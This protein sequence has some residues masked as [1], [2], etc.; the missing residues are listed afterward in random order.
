MTDDAEESEAQ[1]GWKEIAA[2]LRQTLAGKSREAGNLS[3]DD[4]QK[5]VEAC[6]LAQWLEQAAADFD[7]EIELNKGRIV[8]S[9]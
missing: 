5:F 2:N 4:F 3:A 8:F 6:R 7:H 1:A 9:D